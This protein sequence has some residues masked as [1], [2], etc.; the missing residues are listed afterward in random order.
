MKLTNYLH[1]EDQLAV[2]IPTVNNLRQIHPKIQAHPE[3]GPKF[4]EHLKPKLAAA[5]ERIL[6]KPISVE[7][8]S[9]TILRSHLLDMA[10]GFG[11]EKCLTTSEELV[12]EW[13]TNETWN[14]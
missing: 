5:L 12:Q 3:L 14:P 7:L 2:W 9:N 4:Q 13:M 6:Y 1:K 8:P 11:D 10:C